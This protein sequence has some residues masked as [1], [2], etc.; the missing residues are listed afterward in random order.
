MTDLIQSTNKQNDDS[1]P[2]DLKAKFFDFITI[3]AHA[4]FT[5]FN[6]FVIILIIISVALFN[7]STYQTDPK[8]VS[9]ITI[10]L[11]I[12]TGLLGGVL[13]KRWDD[14]TQEKVIVTR[15]KSANRS[16]QLLLSRSVSLEKRI[17]TYSYRYQDKTYYKKLTKEVITTYF[18]EIIDEFFSLEEEIVNSIEDWVDIIPYAD[19]KN[20]ILEMRKIK[21]DF[22]TK[23]I[24][25]EKINTA[26]KEEN[27]KTQE[28]KRILE[29]EKFTIE[30]ELE[31]LSVELHKKDLQSSVP[32]LSGSLLT[33][34]SGTNP[35][36]YD[37]P[38]I[39]NF[40]T[41]IPRINHIISFEDCIKNAYNSTNKKGENGK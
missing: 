6:P 28:E 33:N 2:K 20:Q 34:S 38:D 11:S 26:L 29:K 27:E 1:F 17:R 5:L 18:E 35:S 7:F 12:I 41:Y 8:V 32:F 40:L 24:A 39:P 31:I 25:L 22:I 37:S 3:W 4:L 23:Q 15:A 36:L 16:L 19:V 9:F 21:E 10:I 14:Y 13:S 30:K